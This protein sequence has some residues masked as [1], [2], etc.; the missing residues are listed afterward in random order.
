PT[1][2]ALA[3]LIAALALGGAGDLLLRATPWGLN[4][5]VATI[6]LVGASALLVRR[7]GVRTGPATYSLAA[8]VL[9]IGM[10]FVHR[11]TRTLVA[12][13]LVALLVTLA[14][15]AAQLQGRH[16]ATLHPSGFLRTLFVG[17]WATIIGGLLLAA[18]DVRW[19]ELHQGRRFGG[20]RPIAVGVLLAIPLL[21]VFGALFASADRV[22]G[23]ALE[24]AI[25]F[26]IESLMSHA[27]VVGV[28]TALAAGY[29]RWCLLV[30]S[31]SSGALGSTTS[32]GI[33]PVATALSLLNMLF[34]L[35][36]AVQLRYFFGGAAL[37][38]RTTGL[39]YAEY[40]REGFFQLFTAGVL[41]LPVIL[42]ASH[43]VR[44]EPARGIGIFRALAAVLL[45][46]LA[47]IMI[48]AFERLRLYVGAYGL[49]EARLYATAFMILL[50]GV[51][52]WLAW[53]TLRGRGERFVAGAL[54]QAFAA[55]LAL[56]LLNPD[57][58]I[59]RAN[60]RRMAAGRPFDA[61]YALSL[62]ADAVPT[63]LR[64]LPTLD[65]A[66]RCLV[67]DHLLET[68]SGDAATDWRTWNWGRA[69]AVALVR[70]Q[71]DALRAVPCPL[72]VRDEG[73]RPR[74]RP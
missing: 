46:L 45:L 25:A 22:F 58:L 38:E 42:G 15:A 34:L 27:V 28:C 48:A 36:V 16:I 11:D 5:T 14:L 60:L 23:T 41:T 1:R 67:V 44:H 32:L 12:L 68:W 3:L 71:Q 7:H 56:H 30:R 37:V 69:H 55:L 33:V 2:L 49:S 40:A 64:A 51:F 61:A 72:R 50:I 47:I 17:G 31:A 4:A 70:E 18:E 43:A 53:T 73:D 20:A 24:R 63:L 10:A 8:A 21:V 35:F 29:L 6:L 54:V 66:G 62:S 19:E 9:I 65:P 57:A 52:G 39:T 13:D 26:D 74:R 59:T